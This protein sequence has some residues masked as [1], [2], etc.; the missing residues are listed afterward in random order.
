MN[1]T[2]AMALEALKAEV[3][4]IKAVLAEMMR[5]VEALEKRKVAK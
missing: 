3:Q 5:K 2:E 1:Y 4:A